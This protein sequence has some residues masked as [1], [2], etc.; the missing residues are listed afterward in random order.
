MSKK[1]FDVAVA[2]NPELA[3]EY[4][5]LPSADDDP[6]VLLAKAVA[7]EVEKRRRKEPHAAFF[8]AVELAGRLPADDAIPA[9]ESKV[10]PEDRCATKVGPK[11]KIVFWPVLQEFILWVGAYSGPTKEAPD[12]VAAAKRLAELE[13]YRRTGVQKC[14]KTCDYEYKQA[15]KF[16]TIDFSE[17]S[18]LNLNQ[19]Q[20]S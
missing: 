15:R 17:W 18:A 5:L 2:L 14:F 1:K 16:L 4:A 13:H 12:V 10:I 9:S 11:P 7:R 6:R 8:H 19:P 20:A 3:F